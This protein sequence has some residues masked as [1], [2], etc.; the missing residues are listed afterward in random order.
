[1]NFIITGDL[2]NLFITVTDDPRIADRQFTAGW[3]KA[4]LEVLTVSGTTVL[5][6][7]IN[8][9]GVCSAQPTGTRG[10]FV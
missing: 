10:A 8:N 6:V 7:Q 1:M 3:S 5:T 9:P 4:E 2:E